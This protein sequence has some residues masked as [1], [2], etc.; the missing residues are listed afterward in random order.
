[1]KELLDDV[2]VE[3]LA[4][5][6][7]V[8]VRDAVG[9]DVAAA[10]HVA[11]LAQLCGGMVRGLRADMGEEVTVQAGERDVT[12]PFVHRTVLVGII[13]QFYQPAL[14]TAPGILSRT[15]THQPVII[16][17]QLLMGLRFQIA[18]FFVRHNSKKFDDIPIPPTAPHP[19]AVSCA[20]GARRCSLPPNRARHTCHTAGEHTIPCP[21]GRTPDLSPSA[22]LR[23]YTTC[24]LPA[25]SCALP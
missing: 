8:V 19:S 7:H 2:T 22:F 24:P 5:E 18:I 13:H 1:M 16:F 23:W 10:L 15:L 9:V 4:D 12:L 11:K 6:L 14:R 17:H 21:A 25:C 3:L 20:E